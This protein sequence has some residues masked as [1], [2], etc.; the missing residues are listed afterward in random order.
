[1]QREALVCNISRIKSKQVK[2]TAVL[3]DGVLVLV[4][5]RSWVLLDEVINRLSLMVVVQVIS[6]HLKSHFLTPPLLPVGVVYFYRLYKKK[7]GMKCNFSNRSTN[8]VIINSFVL[9]A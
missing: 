5:R 4:T 6:M 1:M 8:G 2:P 3:L 9:L 7:V